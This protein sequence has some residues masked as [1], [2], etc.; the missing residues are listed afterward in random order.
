MKENIIKIA[1]VVLA[2]VLGLLIYGILIAPKKQVVANLRKNITR[3]RS[4]IKTITGNETFST[5][6]PAEQKKFEKELAILK[7]K[8][9][10]DKEIPRVIDQI[11]AQAGKG[12]KIDYDL[13]QVKNIVTENNYKRLSIDLRFATTFSS[14]DRYLSQLKHL[15]TAVRI[16]NLNIQTP[17]AGSGGISVQM[18]ISVFVL[19]EAI[20]AASAAKPKEYAASSANPFYS[21]KNLPAAAPAAAPVITRVVTPE[22]IKL[23][24]IFSVKSSKMALINDKIVTKGGTV[25][26][27]T[28]IEI[29]DNRVILQKG[30]IKKELRIS[31]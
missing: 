11:V 28:V 7:A 16:D 26:G 24:G 15:P 17:A 9:P 30:R 23:Q 29:G 27:Y 31:I 25:N 13:I 21:K 20:R 6:G 8:I 10:T 18:A 12:I 22:A 19:P 14:F 2:L 5:G 1:T 4:Q 3:M